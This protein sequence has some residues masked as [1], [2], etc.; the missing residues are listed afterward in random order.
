MTSTVLFFGGETIS[1]TQ[2]KKGINGT[3]ETRGY[4]QLPYNGIVNGEFAHYTEIPG[5]IEDLI[6]ELKIVRGGVLTI[7]VPSCFCNISVRPEQRSF[8]KHKRIGGKIIKD[9]LDGGRAAYYKL[10]GGVPIIDAR[11]EIAVSI[12]AQVVNF[13]VAPVFLDIIHQCHSILRIFK[14]IRFVPVAQAEATYMVPTHMRDRT[15][16]LVSC[17]MTDTTVAVCVGDQIVACVT[18]DMGTAHVID[19]IC[20]VKNVD[21]LTAKGMFDRYDSAD[22]DGIAEVVNARLEDM[23]DQIK[24]IVYRLDLGL[25]KRPFYMCG[26]YIDAVYGAK[27]VFSKCLRAQFTECMCPLYE[28]NPPDTT[29]RDAVIISSLG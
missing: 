14:S 24:D 3:Y 28:I 13:G 2:A 20:L 5:I 22:I 16:T 4:A 25:I 10:D 1:L 29:T 21:Y 19:D 8:P 18:F 12:E 6:T 11:G 15:C 26:G 27:E 7:G 23:G 9:L 17:K